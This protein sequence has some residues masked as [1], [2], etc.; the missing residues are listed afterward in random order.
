LAAK[1]ELKAQLAEAKSAAGTTISEVLSSSSAATPSGLC[2]SDDSCYDVFSPLVEE[3]LAVDYDFPA[4]SKHP[5]EAS[6][7]QVGAAFVG[8]DVEVP[9]VRVDVRRNIAGKAW[10][11]A[12]N[13]DAAAEVEKTL[14]CALGAAIPGEYFPVAGSTSFSEKAGGMTADDANKI[15]KATHSVAGD[16]LMSEA[17]P[18]DGRGVYLTHAGDYAAWINHEDHLRLFAQ[19]TKGGVGATVLK[20]L[21]TLQKLKAAAQ[22]TF[23]EGDRLGAL[24]ADPAQAGTAL[25]FALELQCPLVLKN[26]KLLAAMA[27]SYRVKFDSVVSLVMTYSAPCGQS[28]IGATR[29]VLR[30]IKQL[31]SLERRLARGGSIFELEDGLGDRPLEGLLDP[32]ACPE[33]LPDLSNHHSDVAE[34]LR[35]N[36]QLYDQLRSARTASGAT[37]A[38]CIKPGLDSEGHAHLPVA[39]IVAADESCFTVFAP[40]FDV[41]INKR[42][43]HPPDAKHETDIAPEKI[44]VEPFDLDGKYVK[45]VTYRTGRNLR[46]LPLASALDVLQRREVERVLVK[47]L[48]TVVG[49]GGG[50]YYPLRDSSSYA[51]K[52]EGMTQE[53][54]EKLAKSGAL[55][56]EPDSKVAL[57]AGLGRHWPD[58]RGVFVSAT[59]TWHAWVNEEDHLR[60]MVKQPG[61]AFK[62]AFERLAELLQ[63]LEGHVKE[64]DCEF[65]HNDHLGYL[66][67]DVSNLGTGLR[68]T[69]TLALKHL[70]ADDLEAICQSHELVFSRAGEETVVRNRRVIGKSEVVIV[71]SMVKGVAEIVKRERECAEAA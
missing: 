57:A 38:R 42:L 50:D 44:A 51:P 8:V 71:N 12:K 61:N 62:A 54:E 29:H 69:A 41:I 23:S 53:E 58:A 1:T 20:L 22:L 15:R 18:K 17:D 3:V 46:G 32:L 34:A 63:A 26:E 66:A 43:Q 5:A 30:A 37:L 67:T 45:E 10:P 52:P 35:G 28:A 25:T 40:L 56:L 31:Q 9:F 11:R 19:A 13:G 70:A 2:F 59:N 14:T 64:A 24:T 21:A 47:S 7:D 65:M 27:T 60:I 68:V 39:G 4:S 33:K 55:F 16:L 48:L 49:D 6:L 36:P